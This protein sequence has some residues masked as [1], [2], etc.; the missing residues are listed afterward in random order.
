MLTMRHDLLGSGTIGPNLSGLFS[1]FY[2]LTFE[3][4]KPWTMERLE[5]RLRNP[6]QVSSHA[7]MPPVV[8]DTGEVRGLK[9]IF[10]VKK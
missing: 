10:E 2:P 6:R 7:L 1:P 4:T 5:Q 8:L 9:G 3:G